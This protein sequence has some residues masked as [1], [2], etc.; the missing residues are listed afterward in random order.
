[1]FSTDNP[2]P[3]HRSEADIALSQLACSSRAFKALV[4]SYRLTQMEEGRSLLSLG[5]SSDP[6]M[7]LKALIQLASQ[8]QK[9]ITWL[10]LKHCKITGKGCSI[11]GELKDMRH[12]DL[13][14]SG[15]RDEGLIHI[16]KLENLLSLSLKRCEGLT[17][18]ALSQITNLKKLELFNLALWEAYA[19]SSKGLNFIANLTTLRQLKLDSS[20]RICDADL[21]CLA[22]LGSLQKLSLRGVLGLPKPFAQQEQVFLFNFDQTITKLN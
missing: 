5:I 10:N 15:I 3:W 8:K 18:Q 22:K 6:E 7:G 19:I 17:D 2:I 13:G 11:I 12:L 21:P 1:M 16:G 9:A 20:Y 14:E 4:D